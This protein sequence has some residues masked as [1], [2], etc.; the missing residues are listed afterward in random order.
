[1]RVANSTRGRKCNANPVT[2]LI[3][4]T[5]ILIELSATDRKT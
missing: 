4:A 3:F 5:W 2:F 1:M